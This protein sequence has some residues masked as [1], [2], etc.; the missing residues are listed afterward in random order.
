MNF[1]RYLRLKYLKILRIKDSPS[2]IAKGV[3][4]GVAL[5]FLPLPFISIFISFVVA[6]FLRFNTIAAV[7]ATILFKGAI[8]FFYAFNIAVGKL[9]LKGKAPQS[10]TIPNTN[11]DTSF[12]D[13]KRLLHGS[14]V[15]LLGSVV[16][17]IIFWIIVYFVI[18][19]LLE[20]RR[21]RRLKKILA[22][23]K[24]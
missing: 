7:T 3:A 1:V 19:W 12:L 10:I 22:K 11:V 17:S 9:L 20:K 14:D 6:K 16:N 4:L 24:K 15:F 5:D 8:P 23:K 13:F 21:E 18:R 2:Q